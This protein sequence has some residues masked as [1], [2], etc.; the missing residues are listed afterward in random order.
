MPHHSSVILHIR[1]LNVFGVIQDSDVDDVDG[2]RI[3]TIPVTI[4]GV[5]IAYIEKTDLDTGNERHWIGGNEYR[6]VFCY[7][8]SILNT[9]CFSY[10][11]SGT[12]SSEIST[13]NQ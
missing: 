4:K 11:V 2:K 8:V 6:F 9:Y 7:L 1:T 12:V 13:V 10:L 5:H 3:N